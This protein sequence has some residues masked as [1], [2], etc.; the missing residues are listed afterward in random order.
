[1]YHKKLEAD[2]RCPLEYGLE[3]FGGK[4]KECQPPLNRLRE[5]AR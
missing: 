4:W 3:V 2:I 1:M 5:N